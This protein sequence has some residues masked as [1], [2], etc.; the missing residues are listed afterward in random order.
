LG[1]TENVV[2]KGHYNIF[3]RVLSF[4]QSVIYSPM[5]HTHIHSHTTD[6]VF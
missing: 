4:S 2:H 1:C 3:I 5:L 6:A